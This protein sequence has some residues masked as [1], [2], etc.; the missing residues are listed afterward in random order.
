VAISKEA[1]VGLLALT[2][3][4][5]LY[6]GFNFLKGYEI[7]SHT[8]KYFV[9]YENV[10]GLTVSNPVTLNGLAVGRV[11]E[12]ALMAENQ[13]KILVTLDVDED[14]K[15]GDST[16]AFLANTDLLGGKSIELEIGNNTK[17]YKGGETLIPR[18][19]QDITAALTAKAMPIL[20]NLD[21]TV[22]KLNK[23]FGDEVGKSVASTLHNLELASSGLNT[24]VNVNQKNIAAITGNLASLSA[25][26]SQTEKQLKPVIA[27][28]DSLAESLNDMELK[29]TVANA[30]L[31][32]QNIEKLTAKINQG[33]G[34]L[35]QLVNDKEL[36]TN[37]T[38]ASDN[39]NKL[40]ED[41][42]KNPKRYV[43]I[44]VF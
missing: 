9:I 12:I 20:S 42:Q 43:K 31:A 39:L 27:K 16:Y 38:A 14:V 33:E 6:L 40:L 3:G 37:L 32:L 10:D 26:L 19:K 41:I 4:I 18:K 44:S 28:M 23:V 36:Y 7:F 25:S 11:D 15:V 29:Q 13:N 22:I 1:K 24:M 30:N 5:I 35:G 2:A 21:S 8:N 17:L 34:S